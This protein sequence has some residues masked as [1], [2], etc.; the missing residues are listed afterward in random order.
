MQ[1]ENQVSLSVANQLPDFI[2]EEYPKFEKFLSAYY[3][4][5]ERGGGSVGILNNLDSYF[6]L[7]KYDLKKLAGRTRI[8]GDITSTTKNIQVES[9][10]PL[11]DENG[12]VL[13]GDE[14]I[15]Y[16]SKKKLH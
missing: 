12:T 16:F 7:S 1:N 2:R 4:S 8:L 11:P 15:Y 10:D 6:N 9:T 13:I 3:G 5:V 14:V